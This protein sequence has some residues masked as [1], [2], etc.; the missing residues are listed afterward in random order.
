MIGGGGI[1]NKG[2]GERGRE[3]GGGGKNRVKRR[4]GFLK[5]ES[6]E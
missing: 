4:R 5:I 3:K 2:K 6:K 1:R